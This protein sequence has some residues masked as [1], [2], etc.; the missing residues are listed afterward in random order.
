MLIR[1]IFSNVLILVLTLLSVTAI[2]QKQVDLNALEEE[3]PG[4]FSGRYFRGGIGISGASH[5]FGTFYEGISVSPFNVNLEFGTRIKRTYGIYFG[6]CINM[7]LKETAIGSGY[8]GIPTDLQQWTQS[9]I[10]L[11]G[12]LYLKGGNSYF[13]PEAGVGVGLIETTEMYEEGSLGIHTALKYGYDWHILEKFYIGAQA[14][15]GY[16]HCWHDDDGIDPGTGEVLIANTFM[17]GV[18]LT[19]KI[20]N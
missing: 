1:R 9:S 15:I 7:M 14:Y 6:I 8:T 11:G 5:S 13:A 19:I 18:N 10:N 17:Y 16:D 4:L 2:G 12:L 20:G 3:N